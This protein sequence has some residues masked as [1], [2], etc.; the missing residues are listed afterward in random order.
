M[1]ID[2]RIMSAIHAYREAMADDP[3]SATREAMIQC[4]ASVEELLARLAGLGYPPTFGLEDRATPAQLAAARK[5]LGRSAPRVVEIFWEQV[6]GIYL[7]GEDYGH[8]G[9][10]DE[11]GM[12]KSTTDVLQVDGL[13]QEWLGY[14]AQ[15][16]AVDRETDRILLPLA[17]D[18]MQKDDLGTGD[19]QGVWLGDDDWKPRWAAD[20]TW[21]GLR[22][23]DLAEE[24]DQ[25]DFLTYLRATILECGGF[26][27]LLG[28]REFESLRRKLVAGLPPF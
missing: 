11:R 27:G 23:P 10:F 22:W 16:V 8:C 3:E 24:T 7:G 20:S 2:P 6:G 26:P 9:F 21:P 1:T 12:R 15:E 28:V 18:H 17:P 4:R 5:I 13:S 25:P 19:P 14:L